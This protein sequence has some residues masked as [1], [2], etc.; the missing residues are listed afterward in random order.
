[1]GSQGDNSLIT[2]VFMFISIT[3]ITINTLIIILYSRKKFTLL[4][5]RPA[6]RQVCWPGHFI[7]LLLFFRTL[8]PS[9]GV[10]VVFTFRKIK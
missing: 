1:M 10:N 2:I 4:V 7:K 9:S 8:Y 6:N 3:T 5:N